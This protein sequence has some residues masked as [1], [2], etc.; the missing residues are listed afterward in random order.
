MYITIII[1]EK[2]K[3]KKSWYNIIIEKDIYLI[4]TVLWWIMEIELPDK[5]IKI[6]IP[7][8]LQINENIIISWQWFKKWTWILSWKWNIIIKPHI[9]IPKILSKEEKKLYEKIKNL[10]K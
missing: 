3:W 10:K 4:D 7:K 2:S 8:W 6:K 9:K 5:K 1:D